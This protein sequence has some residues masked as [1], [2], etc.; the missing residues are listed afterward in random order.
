MPHFRGIVG[1][2]YSRPTLHNIRYAHYIPTNR[3]G[4]GLLGSVA[5]MQQ[6]HLLCVVFLQ[7][8]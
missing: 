2:W 8:N 4:V 5:S 6:P 1:H 7:Q 3:K